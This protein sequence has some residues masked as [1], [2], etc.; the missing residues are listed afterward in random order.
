MKNKQPGRQTVNVLSFHLCI[1]SGNNRV[2]TVD[3]PSA[4]DLAAMARADAII[5][6]QACRYHLY[7]AARRLC[8]HV[9]PDYDVFF[10]YPGKTGQAVLFR[11][12]EVPH[13][14]SVTCGRIEEIHAAALPFAYPFVFKS[15]WGGEGNGVF[16]VAD[17]EELR[18]CL[19]RGSQWQ[20]RGRPGVVLQEYIPTNGRSL[21][22]VVI[23]D[24]YYP[25]WRT[26]AGDAFYTNLAKGAKIDRNSFPALQEKAVTAT[27]DFC[28]RTRI[29]LAGFDFLFDMRQPDPVPLFLEI[30]FCFRCKGLG[31]VDDYHRLLEKGIRAWLNRIAGE[32]PSLPLDIAG[33]KDVQ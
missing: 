1:E 11:E 6:P 12:M 3:S 5:L 15:A 19:A 2:A 17:E 25:Y 31:G 24:D 21:R 18:R 13:P 30:N 8:P 23:A 7:V 14:R 26:A 4:D 22:V 9:F 20:E 33:E 16:P 28:R 32:Q 10:A 27:K 29:N